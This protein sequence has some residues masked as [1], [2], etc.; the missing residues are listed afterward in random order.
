ML[1]T[2]AGAGRLEATPEVGGRR[3]GSAQPCRRSRPGAS[4]G[5][6][7]R[8]VPAR[9]RRTGP[10]ACRVAD[11]RAGGHADI[12]LRETGCITCNQSG[13]LPGRARGATNDA[14]VR[15][16]PR[17]CGAGRAAVAEPGDDAPDATGCSRVHRGASRCND[18]AG[19]ATESAASSLHQI[20]ADREVPGHRSRAARPAGR[21]H[22]RAARCAA[23]SACSREVPNV[24]SDATPRPST[25][26][27][28]VWRIQCMLTC[29]VL[30][31]GRCSPRRSHR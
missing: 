19:H 17:S 2:S 27:R 10:S 15:R 21:G 24:A 6:R 31:H 1:N 30:T 11:G 29:W 9:P 16:V 20:Q 28:M 13:W 26:V 18:D 7:L 22:R 23:G 3:Y 4:A 14:E 12:G 8:C 5:R 25:Q